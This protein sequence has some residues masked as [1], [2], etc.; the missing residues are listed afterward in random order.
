MRHEKSTPSMDTSS[1][2]TSGTSFSDT[3]IRH[4]PSVFFL[5]MAESNGVSLRID[6][7][8]SFPGMGSS[9][10]NAK[11]VETTSL[12]KGGMETACRVSPSQ[13]AAWMP[14]MD[15]IMVAAFAS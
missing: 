3:T 9:W 4:V 6:L 2:S 10:I 8:S 7:I 14:T 5:D 12:A 1:P 13:S 15:S 11:Y